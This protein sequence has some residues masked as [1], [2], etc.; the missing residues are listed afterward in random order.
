MAAI[1]SKLPQNMG[2]NRYRDISACKKL[3]YYEIELEKE[4]DR[5][6]LLSLPLLLLI[7]QFQLILEFFYSLDDETRVHLME[8][9]DYINASF[10]NV[11]ACRHSHALEPTAFTM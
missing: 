8:G 5:I 7:L 10:I 11:S 2:R 6:P 3:A 9:P 1:A 4:R